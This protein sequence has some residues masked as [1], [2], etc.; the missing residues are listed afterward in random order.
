MDRRAVR[1][2][3]GVALGVVMGVVAV[4]L[5]VAGADG[6]RAFDAIGGGVGG[7]R[8]GDRY[9]DVCAGGVAV[10]N[11]GDNA[12]LVR[13]CAALLT[14]RDALVGD[15]TASA[16]A[17]E[18]DWAA[19]RRIHSWEGVG[20]TLVD[21]G[22]AYRV[23]EVGLSNKRLTGFIHSE[24]H[25]VARLEEVSLNGNQLTGGIP[26]EIGD[27]GNL[28]TLNLSNNR[29]SGSIPAELGRL[30]N[31]QTL[32][33]HNN[34]LTGALPA[35]L[36]NLTN[37]AL[38]GFGRNEFSG[39]IPVSLRDILHTWDVTDIGLAFCDVATA[40]AGLD[41]TATA[42]AVASATAEAAPA[43]A[44][45]TA[46]SE[47]NRTGTV[48]PTPTSDAAGTAATPTATATRIPVPTATR[49]AA[50][51]ATATRVPAPAADVIERLI[52]LER[53]VAALA[54]RVAALEARSQ[55]GVATATPVGH[56]CVRE[57]PEG[58]WF[59]GTWAAGCVTSHP[60]ASNPGGVYYARFYTF[61]LAAAA[62][63]TIT[64]SSDE[65]APHLLLLR[66]AG[67]G[68]AIVREASPVSVDPNTDEIT[69]S[70]T[71]A[72]T[73]RLDAGS[74]TIESTTYYAGKTGDFRLSLAVE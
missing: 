31:L 19:S 74:Y 68:G 17:G 4:S 32:L 22:A 40:T 28:V 46:T 12:G 5:V 20:I 66:G 50:P 39:C 49:T 15:L 51:T 10:P 63:V 29:L 65:A 62:D 38:M 71:I 45:P 69:I 41:A 16:D 7:E 72:I 27:L 54:S 30:V 60:P 11:P 18:L 13:D 35:E 58:A 73:T 56:N 53:Q 48:T 47:A 70:D 1:V 64:L 37:L 36:G 9:E 8:G 14:L 52:A 42:A 2:V 33:L 67:R 26:R 23:T 43:T 6:A 21:D 44:T 59:G 55:G 34:R 61:T 25:K 57:V 24:I 3:M